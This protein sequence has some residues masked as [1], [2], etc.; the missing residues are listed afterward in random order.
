MRRESYNDLIFQLGD[1]ARERLA[2][3]P[4]A[5]Q[6]MQRVFRAE[7]ALVARQEELA[8][9]EQQMNDE[10]AQHQDLL[11]R[12]EEEKKGLQATVK[13]YRKAV[14]AIEGRVR[15]LRKKLAT[16]RADVR[17][18]AVNLKK[19]E[20]KLQDYEMTVNDPQKLEVARQNLKKLRLANMR[21]NREI[22]D[23]EHELDRALTPEP[24]Q[25]GADGVLAHK[26]LLELE[27]EAG[28][29]AAGFEE[30]MVELDQ[31]IAQK[32]QEVA[33]AED[34]LDQALFLLGE[35]CYAQRLADP[36]LAALYPRIDRAK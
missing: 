11:A 23:L 19:E 15:E 18:A 9:L 30:R 3:R 31:A 2:T 34:Y 25:P 33:A 29:Q 22:E 10:D 28:Q 35:E 13:R 6:S 27:D 26:R 32:E 4:T 36:A 12:A 14:D 17:Y 24:G 7:E 8:S 20:K 16:R 21:A 5:P 1:L